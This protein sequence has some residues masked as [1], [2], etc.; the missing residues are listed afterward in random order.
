MGRPKNSHNRE[1]VAEVVRDEIKEQEVVTAPE[2]SISELQAEAIQNKVIMD[3]HDSQKIQKDVMLMKV[4]DLDE[5]IKYLTKRMVEMDTEYNQ[6]RKLVDG[7]NGSIAGAQAE[8]SRLRSEFTKQNNQAI[9]SL[10][11]ERAEIEKADATLRTLINQNNSLLVTNKQTESKLATERQ[12][13][14]SQ[15]YEMKK[16]LDQ[17]QTEWTKREKDILEREK[18]LKDEREAFENERNTI[19]PELDKISSV[20]NENILLLQEVERGQTNIRNLMLGIESE[21]QVLAESKLIHEGK[22]KQKELELANLEK[23]NRE[24]E[25]N[26][27]DFDLEVRARS[28]KADKM[29][30]TMQ[31]EKEASGK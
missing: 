27:K 24:W 20:K 23:K 26:L 18:A 2:K 6:R 19:Q 9:E 13:A 8:L 11:K 1:K 5:H 31:L 7:I 12:L 22:M 15:V 4:R 10:A 14:Q 17:N 29:L 28:A 21:K 16:A 25:Q 30:R 3:M